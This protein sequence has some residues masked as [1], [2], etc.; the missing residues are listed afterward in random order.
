VSRVLC[1][2]LLYHEHNPVKAMELAAYA[3]V[4][5]KYEDWWWKARLAKCYY[6]LGL[7][8]DAEKQFKSSLR[9]Q[10]MVVT[11]LELCK[12]YIKLDQPKTAMEWYQRASEAHPSNPQ[13][14]LG[15]AR[16]YDALND[17]EHGVAV[18]QRVLELDPSNAEAI[19][20]LA[21]N[22]FYS[23]QPEVAL[24]YYRRLVQMGVNTAELWNNLGLCC[25]YA[26]QYDMTLNCFERALQLADDSNMADVWYNIGHLAIG[27]GDLGLAY[28]AFKIAISVNSD[29]AEA[30]NNLGVLEL[31]KNSRDQAR[32]NFATA[33][34]LAD[35]AFEPFYNAALL[36]YKMGDFQESFTL[37]QKA[38]AA[39]PGHTESKE[40]SK[41][42][43]AAFDSV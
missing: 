43:K 37:V 36:A 24:R 20:C 5:E 10:S 9:D 1:D 4:Y 11:A 16:I 33:Q 18:Y 8:R 25:F 13:L 27:I 28:Q 12:V 15:I 31:R 34:R 40:L 2:Y 26:S 32:S 7:L 21:S 29:H 38:L 3:T 35:F 19:A 41:Q 42:L 39:Y 30:Y 6:Q 22:H 14:L 17:L 23:D